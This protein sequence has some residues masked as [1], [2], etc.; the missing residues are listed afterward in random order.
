MLRWLKNLVYLQEKRSFH[1]ETLVYFALFVGGM[2]LLMEHFLV[3]FSGYPL[4]QNFLLYVSWYWLCIFAFGLPVRLL[5]PPPWT[6]RIN[7]MLVGLFLGFLPPIIDVLAG[8]WGETLVGKD[9]FAYKYVTNFP[10]GW[11]LLL[12]DDERQMPV[13]EGAILWA[14]IGFTAAYLWVR[15]RSWWRALLGGFLAY[16]VCVLMGAL[17]PTYTRRFYDAYIQTSGFQHALVYAQTTL[18]LA[19]YLGIYRPRLLLHIAKR[20]AHA[21]PLLGL[22]SVGYAWVKPLGFDVLWPLALITFCGMMTIAQNDHWDDKEEQP[23]AEP[24]VYSHDIIV[25]GTT[26]VLLAATA[27][28]EDRYAGLLLTIYGVA[29][30]LYNSQLYRGKRYFPANLKLEGIWGGSAFLIG[31]LWASEPIQALALNDPTSPGFQQGD[32][33]APIPS[34][35]GPDLAIAALLAFGGWSLLAALKD[36]KDVETDLELGTQTLFTLLVRRGVA[37]EHV[38]TRLRITAF[39]CMLVASFGPFF[40]DRISIWVSFA[41]TVFA[42]IAALW[43][44]QANARR[45]FVVTLISMSAM[46]FALAIGLSVP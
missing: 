37:R 19:L 33:L 27:L 44:D 12:I 40:L 10:E 26:L 7:V 32:F 20:F 30:Y 24:R 22:C 43:V 16:G 38:A 46:L 17:L 25:F 21:L 13:G 2:R 3:G 6:E 1:G 23:D 34:L 18:A 11:P 15:T 42:A 31:A 28:H 41:M 4:F 39:I 14:A 9:G 29:S 8:T 5:S 45:G 36:E 35:F